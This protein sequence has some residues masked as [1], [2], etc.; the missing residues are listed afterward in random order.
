MN[1]QNPKRL[2]ITTSDALSIIKI[3]SRKNSLYESIMESCGVVDDADACV[4]MREFDKLITSKLLGED[5]NEDKKHDYQC[6]Q[7]KL[8]SEY[9]P[10]IDEYRKTI[11]NDNL[12]TE[13]DDDRGDPHITVKYGIVDVDIDQLKDKLSD[14]GPIVV[15]LGDVSK[16]ECG[17]YD[18]IKIDVDS[19]DLHR[20]NSLINKYAPHIDTYD[21][22]SPH[23]TI[24]YVKSGSSDACCGDNTF[25][26]DEIE[27]DH[28]LLSDRDGQIHE[29]PLGKSSE[30]VS[31]ST[32]KSAVERIHRKTR[33]NKP[34]QHRDV[35]PVP[36]KK[37]NND[38]RNTSTGRRNL[39]GWR[40][41]QQTKWK[42]NHPEKFTEAIEFINRSRD[43]STEDIIAEIK[44]LKH[45]SR[46]AILLD[47]YNKRYDN[48]EYKYLSDLLSNVYDGN[49]LVES[50][51][52]CDDTYDDF[53]KE[54]GTIVEQFRVL[55]PLVWVEKYIIKGS[56]IVE[57]IVVGDEYMSERFRNNRDRHLAFLVDE[58]IR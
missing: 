47:G 13:E 44:S 7:V 21:E 45:P 30:V 50:Y 22:Y 31:E 48:E 27:F 51:Y 54:L 57:Y 25:N 14:F 4:L 18:V 17:D 10:R 1:D 8:P 34:V 26:G 28:V 15:K 29:I 5:N 39:S 40:N 12:H 37:G 19:D 16:F 46:L 38:P 11:D 49:Q 52:C 58:L 33:V 2:E 55:K 9:L 41:R 56:N 32:P 23:V 3:L 42:R 24:A 36:K 20:L 43:M 6:I 35:A 53:I